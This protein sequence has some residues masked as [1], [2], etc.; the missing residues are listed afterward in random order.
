VRFSSEGRDWWGG[1]LPLT[2]DAEDAWI[3]VAIP[4]SANL[5]M[6]QSRWYLL[7]ITAL[8]ILALGVGMAALL[9]RK[10]SH[11]L[12]ELPKRGIDTQDPEAD[13]RTLI[14]RGEGTHVEFKSTMRMNLHTGKAGKEIELAW[15]KGVAAFLNTEGG[16]LLIGVADDGEMLGLDADG[17]ANDDKCQ[18]HFKNL[19]NSHLGAEYTRF[20]RLELYRIEDKTIAAVECEP[21]DMPAYLRNKGAESFLIRNGPS[22]IELPISKALGYIAGRF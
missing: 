17:F 12:R 22:N 16:V 6:L 5:G 21:A 13:I 19:I 1:F 2:G 15:L 4:V 11:Q 7:A 8:A 10:Y 9:V 14:S 18:L 20:L 3:G